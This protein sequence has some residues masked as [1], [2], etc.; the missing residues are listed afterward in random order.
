MSVI[1]MPIVFL[2]VSKINLCKFHTLNYFKSLAQTHLLLYVLLSCIVVYLWVVTDDRLLYHLD[3][4]GEKTNCHF[5]PI[6][7]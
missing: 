2:G 5:D 1:S 6:K 4:K 7:N 3:M